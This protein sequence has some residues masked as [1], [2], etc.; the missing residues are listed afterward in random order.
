MGA[1]EFVSRPRALLQDFGQSKPNVL[2]AYGL[3]ETIAQYEW[4]CNKRNSTKNRAPKRV[5][6]LDVS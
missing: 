5:P 6:S 4:I 2:D 1:L 3:L